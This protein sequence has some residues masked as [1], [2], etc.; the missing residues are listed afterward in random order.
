M[1]LLW[2]SHYLLTYIEM[3]NLFQSGSPCLVVMGANS[4]SRGHGFESRHLIL[5]GHYIFSHWFVVLFVWKDRKRKKEAGVGP[6]TKIRS[7]FFCS[8]SGLTICFL[9]EVFMKMIAFTP[10]GYWQ[11]RRNRGDLFV[12]ILGVA[13]IVLNYVLDNQ[14]AC[15]LAR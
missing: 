13:W 3:F 11:S 14:V 12:T 7:H 15:R 4:Y 5:D 6:F 10:Y 1:L 9:I 2:L 8:S